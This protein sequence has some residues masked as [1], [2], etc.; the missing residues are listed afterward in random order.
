MNPLEGLNAAQKE[1][2]TAIDG[3]VLV[4]AG[5]GTGKTRIIAHRIAYILKRKKGIARENI[6]ALT[7]TNKAADE[8]HERIGMIL[9]EDAGDMMVCTFHSLGAWMLHEA[10]F[11]MDVPPD[12]RQL[13]EPERWI[14][15]KKLFSE[16]D[17]EYFRNPQ[18]FQSVVSEFSKFI[19]R[20]KNELVTPEQYSAY[21]DAQAARLEQDAPRLVGDIRIE[22]GGQRPGDPI[23]RV[24]A[25]VGEA[26]VDERRAPAR[27]PDERIHE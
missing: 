21:I 12:F 18:G 11:H 26:Q 7:Y 1:A 3:P 19:D 15:I 16:L 27:L 14:I 2:V 22:H 24:V 25:V 4:I 17:L 23:A 20:A 8:M 6:L 9:G 13:E 10:G 5:A